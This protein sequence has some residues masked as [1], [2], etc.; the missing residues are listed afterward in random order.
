MGCVSAK[1]RLESRSCDSKYCALLITAFLGMEVIL[2]A[3]DTPGLRS[4]TK[5]L[6]LM[7]QYQEPRGLA[8][9]NNPNR[10]MFQKTLKYSF[11]FSLSPISSMCGHLEIL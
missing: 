1:Q 10:I 7:I 6:M 2:K 8:P 5:L 4:N 3:Q 11:Y 9:V